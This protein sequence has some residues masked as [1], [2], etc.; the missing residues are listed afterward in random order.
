MTRFKAAGLHL[1][2]SIAL[3]LLVGALLF[4]VW[5]PEPYSV[6]AGA[7]ELILLLMGV[8]V[9]IGPLLTLIVFNRSKPVRLLRLDLAIIGLVQFIAFAYGLSVIVQARP[10]FVVATVDRYML[11]TADQLDDE[12]LA[13]GDRPEFRSRSWTGPRLVAAVP[14]GGPGVPER[15]MAVMAGGK[16]IDRL[17]EFYVPYEQVVDEFM[18]RARSLSELHPDDPDVQQEIDALLREAREDG[19]EIRYL[20]L[21]RQRFS[22]TAVV[23]LATQKPIEVLNL[24]P[25]EASKPDT[26]SEP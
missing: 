17:P 22:Y 7:D 9:C 4:F 6:A 2:I 19:R 1:C 18:Q 11:V 23:D 16:D 10:V 24:D 5:F 25:W 26:N 3:A 21:Q 14:P 8:D 12:D 13:K 15:V 20:P